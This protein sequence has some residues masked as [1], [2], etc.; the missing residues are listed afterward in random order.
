MQT[1]P[2]IATGP[3]PLASILP[4]TLSPRLPAPSPDLDQKVRAREAEELA[5]RRV[6]AVQSLATRL[7]RRYAP[8]RATL[9]GFRVDYQQQR[10]ALRAIRGIVTDGTFDRNVVLYGSVGTGKDHLLAALLYAAAGADRSVAWANGQEV[11]SRFRDAMDT[12][13]SESSLMADFAR[14]EVLG[15]SDPIPPV[16]D[17][18][19]PAAW[20]TELLFRVL[21][22][23]YREMKATWVTCNAEDPQ[24]AAAKLSEP[25]FDRLKDGALLIPCFWPSFRATKN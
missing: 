19:K 8:T 12:K 24:D 3:E 2:R 25:V 18:N 17:P 7:G 5:R 1:A 9:D 14:P 11:Y 23:R 10:E 13:T 4:G 20:R 16:I 22:A 21:D 6:Q 15:I